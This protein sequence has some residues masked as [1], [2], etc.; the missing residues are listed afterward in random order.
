M[1]DNNKS[2]EEQIEKLESVISIILIGGII[3]SLTLVSIGMVLYYSYRGG[4]TNPH[5]TTKWQMGG[6][7]FFVYIGNLISQI[8]P[9]FS[10]NAINIMAVGLVVLIITPFVRVLVSVI[11]FGLIR[12]FKYLLITSFVLILLGSSL[13]IH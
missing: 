12:N 7:N 6:S 4:I 1:I 13:I 5:F 3:L 10:F 9:P 11:F 2:K 8:R